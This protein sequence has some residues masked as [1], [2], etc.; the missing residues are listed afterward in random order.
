MLREMGKMQERAS[1]LLARPVIF[2]P[3][4]S[5]SPYMEWGGR[6][7]EVEEMNEIEYL[8]LTVT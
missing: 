7:S 4:H 2:P 3:V 8:L 1:D 6:Q 5:L